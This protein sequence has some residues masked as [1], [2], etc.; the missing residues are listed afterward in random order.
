MKETVRIFRFMVI[1]TANAIIMAV[2][3]WLMMSSLTFDGDYMVANI[4]AYIIAQVHN[5]M[6]CKYWIFPKERSKNGVWKQI[7]F[8]CSAFGVAYT[9]QFLFLVLLVE[10]LGVNEYLGQFLGLFVYGSV[11]FMANRRITFK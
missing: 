6:W 11:N 1:G 7:V 5:F 4:T 10:G 9:A 8:F 2:V 3:V